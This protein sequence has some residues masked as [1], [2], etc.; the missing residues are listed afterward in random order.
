[1]TNKI[2]AVFDSL[3]FVYVLKKP[4]AVITEDNFHDEVQAGSVI[5]SSAIE[6]LL[7]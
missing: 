7:R 3:E 5:G 1:M 6:S 4:D 2:P